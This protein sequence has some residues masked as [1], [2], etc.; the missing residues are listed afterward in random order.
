MLLS[1]VLPVYNEESTIDLM[2][3]RLRPILRRLPCDY[4]I[5]FVNDGSKDQTLDMLRAVAEDSRI[6]VVSFG[7]NYGHQIAVSAGIDHAAGDAVVIMDADL[8]DPPELLEEMVRLYNLGYDVV[9]PQ[10]KARKA[11]TAFKRITAGMFYG[12]MQRFVDPR[13]QP[14][15]GDFRLL[16]RAVVEQLKQFREHHRFLRGMIASMGF[17]E[18]ILPFERQPRAA[19]ETKYPLRKMLKFAWTAIT[20]FS[21]LPLRASFVLGLVL[22]GV[23]F[24]YMGYI[25]YASLIAHEVVPGWSSIV[26]LQCFFSGAILVAIGLVGDY[27]SRIYEELKG[28]PL[29]IVTETHNLSRADTR[30]HAGRAEAAHS[31]L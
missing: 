17:R 23:S 10:R 16:S 3:D 1:V 13:L 27:V 9:S 28:R 24:I 7:R 18:V 29:Y 14:E 31:G 30:T 19:G 25:L 22:A 12:I 20:S 26:F 15:V 11:D 2:L 4:E 6:R 5:L 21:G 8:Q